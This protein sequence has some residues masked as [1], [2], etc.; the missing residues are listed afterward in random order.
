[1]LIVNL[2][3][4]YCSG[5]YWLNIIHLLHVLVWWRLNRIHKNNDSFH[6]LRSKSKYLPCIYTPSLDPD[7]YLNSSTCYQVFNVIQL[8]L[9]NKLRQMSLPRFLWGPDEYICCHFT[10][11]GLNTCLHF[12]PPPPFSGGSHDLTITVCALLPSP[13]AEHWG[14]YES[15]YAPQ[16]LSKLISCS[17]LRWLT[18]PS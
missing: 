5:K 14:Y 11:L 10:T 2:Y 1:M 7:S 18:C 6:I 15:S 13:H 4:A 12:L 3:I 9:K 16:H 17:A 8:E